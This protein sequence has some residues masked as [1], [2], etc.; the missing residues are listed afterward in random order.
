MA[1][2]QYQ[3]L[4][5]ERT[6]ARF[7]VASIARSSLWL[8]DDHLLFVECTGYTETYKRFYFRD[9]QAITIRKT[10]T[11]AVWNWITGVLTAGCALAVLRSL[12]DGGPESGTVI[13][14]SCVLFFFAI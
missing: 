9:I 7:A 13:F 14:F 2:P 12:R 5:R 3:R 4:T 11:H 1:E 10:T 8:G 6:P